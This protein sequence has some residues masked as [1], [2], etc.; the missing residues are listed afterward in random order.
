MMKGTTN[1]TSTKY[2]VTQ[3]QKPDFKI[4]LKS[5]L[6]IISNSSYLHQKRLLVN[7]TRVNSTKILQE[8]NILTYKYR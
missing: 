4:I 3:A 6:W 5:I 8:R 2:E 1:R 7:S